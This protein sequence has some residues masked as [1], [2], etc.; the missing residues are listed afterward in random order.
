M[1]DFLF[2]LIV[3]LNVLTG[4]GISVF[5]IKKETQKLL[6]EQQVD[7]KKEEVPLN[8]IKQDLESLR[9]KFED[10]YSQMAYQLG[11]VQEIGKGIKEFQNFLRSPK[12]RG[13]I[14]EEI[15]KDLLEQC[16]PRQNFCL[17]YQF[18]E[19]QIIDAIIKTNQGIIPI[20]SKFPM[21]NFRKL[22]EAGPEN[23]KIFQRDFSRDIKR[24]IDQIAK[25]YI[26]PQ[27][28]TVDFALMYVPSEPIYYEISHNQPEILEYGYVKK[29]YFVSPNSF[30]YFLKIIL[31]GLEG[32]KIEE[33]AKK[34]LEG[35]KA[36][37]QE[38]SKFEE[39]LSVLISHI[40]HAKSAS[41]RTQARFFK[42]LSKIERLGEL[43]SP[44]ISKPEI[45]NGEKI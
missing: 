1:S 7:Q 3:F 45:K 39:E 19:G 28:G 32:V 30:Y 10:G 21:E 17:Q 5:Y 2:I 4:I 44:E 23:N 27:E 15:L 24:H 18:R 14:G 9:K 6:K 34:I 37:Q 12:L 36:A 42:L 33:G 20:D 16:L 26:L 31:V 40:E 13:N 35:M 29:V 11:Q 41:D 38:A 43:E 22:T 8:L 25:K